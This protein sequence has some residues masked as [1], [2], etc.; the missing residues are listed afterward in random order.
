M[1]YWNDVLVQN[2]FLS[3]IIAQQIEHTQ[4]NSAPKKLTA[5]KLHLEPPPRNSFAAFNS[6]NQHRSRG[7][8][9]V[10]TVLPPAASA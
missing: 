1:I 4:S 5:A 3:I 6:A 2:T 8:H 7:A 10:S 9:R